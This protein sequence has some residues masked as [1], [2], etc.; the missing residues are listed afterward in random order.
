MT[1][2]KPPL[3][4]VICGVTFEP[5][6]ELKPFQYGLV[7]QHFKQFGYSSCEEQAPIILQIEMPDSTAQGFPD[8]FG[9]TRLVFTNPTDNSVVQFQKDRFLTDWRPSLD[10]SPYPGFDK[11][12]PRFSEYF[13]EFVKVI[14]D[15][16]TPKP[17][18]IVQFELTYLNQLFQGEHWEGLGKLSKL[19]PFMTDLPDTPG[20]AHPEGFAFGINFLRENFGG[21]LHV[22]CGTAVELKGKNKMLQVNFTARGLGEYTTYE[23]VDEWFK[24]A[25]A[26][27]RATHA[28]LFSKELQEE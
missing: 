3:V 1:T 19:F 10:G 17:P 7:W 12:Y 15:L 23:K 24:L 26:E 13:K 25:H 20:M 4:E 21:R 6:Q 22:Q 18:K 8:P 16:G 27:L 14:T 5:L 9:N 28:G 2:T 11:V